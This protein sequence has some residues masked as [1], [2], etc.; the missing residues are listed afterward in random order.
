MRGRIASAGYGG[1][2]T[3]WATENFAVSSGGMGIDE[4]MAV[5][6]DAKTRPPRV[7]AAYCHVGAGAAQLWTGG[8]ITSCRPPMSPGQ[9]CGSSAPSIGGLLKAGG[10]SKPGIAVDPAGQ[11]RHSGC[12]RQGLS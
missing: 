4:I 2:G 12:R 11:D 8:S 5:W 10:D 7:T 9:E 6:A 3:V 1:G